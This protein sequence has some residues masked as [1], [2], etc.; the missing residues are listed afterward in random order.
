M[1]G[2]VVG[3]HVRAEDFDHGGK[4][5]AYA[6][7]GSN[8]PGQYRP[9]ESVAIATTTD[10]GGGYTITNTAAGQWLQYT[11]NVTTSGTYSALFRI[12]TAQ[13]V[14]GKFHLNIDGKNVTGTI[15]APG[16]GGAQVW[17]TVTIKGIKVAPGQRLLRLVMDANGSGG[18]VANFNWIELVRTSA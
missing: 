11:I 14:G 8:T 12:A 13:S 6:T 10:A 1:V 2:E 18:S 16:T 4:N 3:R 9:N 15:T 17:R 7:A 5:I